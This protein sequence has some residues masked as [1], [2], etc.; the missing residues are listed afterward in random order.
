MKN[1][2][3]YK[4]V[5][6]DL[7]KWGIITR[8]DSI[9]ISPDEDQLDDE[10]IYFC[11]DQ[12]DRYFSFDPEAGMYPVDYQDFFENE[13]FKKISKIYN[14]QF[15]IRTQTK[16]ANKEIGESNYLVTISFDSYQI[17]QELK[18][19]SDFYDVDAITE[20]VNNVINELGK[21]NVFEDLFECSFLLAPKSVIN[22]LKERYARSLYL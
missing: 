4:D 8:E 22:E 13:I 3:A 18:D 17:S 5:V 11:L 19:F 7:I 20:L 16:N 1:K 15:T 9:F 6:K 2:D 12:T 21:E 10:P 14:K